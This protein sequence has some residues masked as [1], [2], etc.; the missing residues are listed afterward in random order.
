HEDRAI[1]VRH[2]RRSEQPG[3][4]RKVAPEERPLRGT[5]YIGLGA[6]ERRSRRSRLEKR[7]ESLRA[8]CRKAPELG[9]NRGMNTG[10]TVALKPLMERGNVGKTDQRFGRYRG[11]RRNTRSRNP[12]P[13][14]RQ[15]PHRA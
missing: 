3:E 7:N 14:L 8:P 12:R 5:A 15:Q 2:E 11:S 13:Q 4:D 1:Q 6:G 9:K 10:E